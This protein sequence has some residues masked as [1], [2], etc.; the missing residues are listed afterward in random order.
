ML[1]KFPVKDKNQ[2]M[3]E[4]DLLGNTNECPVYN[5]SYEPRY[6]C[7]TLIHSLFDLAHGKKFPVLC[8]KC[9][10]NSSGKSLM[11]FSKYCS[12]KY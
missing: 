4:D 11:C 10:L 6:C 12:E 2:V 5:C 9:D 1:S 3:N 7:D 8:M